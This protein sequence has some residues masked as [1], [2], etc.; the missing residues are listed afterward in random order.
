M[1]LNIISEIISVDT[2]DCVILVDKDIDTETKKVLKTLGCVSAKGYWVYKLPRDIEPLVSIAHKRVLP[3]IPRL[4]EGAVL[5][6]YKS[7]KWNRE[8]V[9][10]H[11]EE[12]DHYTSLEQKLY[13]IICRTMQKVLMGDKYNN[14]YYELIWDRA[15]EDGHS[16][17]M[18]E[19]KHFYEEYLDW[20][21]ELEAKRKYR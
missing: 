13:G 8:E 3:R 18:V 16:Y 2:L 10:K 1:N 20:M 14:P 21:D 11:N 4:P 6:E 19:V 17:G 5:D 7:V 15:Y 9:A 12:V